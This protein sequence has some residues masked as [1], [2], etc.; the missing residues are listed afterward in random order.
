MGR[1]VAIYEMLRPLIL[2]KAIQLNTEQPTNSNYVCELRHAGKRLTAA[3][4]WLPL[5]SAIYG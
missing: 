5:N 3:S 1:E 2:Y 4:G